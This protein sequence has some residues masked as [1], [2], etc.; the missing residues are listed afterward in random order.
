MFLSGDMFV[1]EGPPP[2][3]LLD[4]RWLWRFLLAILAVT[5]V[6]R[7]I[8]GDI[9]GA[10][11]SG[12]MLC[13]GVVMVRDGMQEMMRYALTYG[14]LCTLN[15]VLDIVPLI[16]GLNGRVRRHTEPVAVINSKGV[17]QIT[18]TLTKR[19]TPFFSAAEG[20]IY[21]AQS[22][23]MLLSPICMLLGA[24]LS[25]SAHLAYQ[26][27]MAPLLDQDIPQQLPA[28]LGNLPQQ[29]AEARQAAAA[30]AASARAE[31]RPA[32]TLS[33]ADARNRPVGQGANPQLTFESF[34]G[35][36]YKL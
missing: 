25:L 32:P 11:L 34:Q 23:A 30:Q 3:D 21:N 4:K 20:F 6:L 2:Q 16:M 12:L 7:I 5:F 27:T 19:T 22:L 29:I 15:F 13:F 31:G 9:A 17:Q 36:G 10:V 33:N 24:C 28:N 18:Y 26:R 8:G 1:L 35:Q 14:I